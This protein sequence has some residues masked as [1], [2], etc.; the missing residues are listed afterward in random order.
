MRLIF[1]C[2]GALLVSTGFSQHPLTTSWNMNTTGDLGTYEYYPGPPPTTSTVNMTDSTDILELCESTDYVFIRT[3]GLPSYLMGPWQMNPN[4]P[5]AI[6]SVYR[7]PKNPQEE[8]G[9]KTAQPTVGAFGVAV[10][11]AKLYGTGD[12]RS[13]NSSNG[14]NDGM[15]DGLWNADAWLSEGTTMDATGGGHPDQN[16]NYHYH[17]TPVALYTDPSTQHSPIIGWAFDGHPIYGPFG[18]TDSLSAGPVT[19]MVSSWELRNITDRTLLPD[20]TTSTPAGPAINGTFPLGTYWEDYEYV[21][22]AG[23]LDEYNGRWC[24][25]P[26]Y[27]TGTYAYFVTVDNSGE[28]QFPYLMGLE[29]YG[30]ILHTNEIG[31]PAG[32]VIDMSDCTPLSID[33]EAFD[34]TIYP[35]PANSILNISGIDGATYTIIDQL[36]RILER[37]QVIQQIDISSFEN[38]TYTILFDKND[39]TAIKRFVKQ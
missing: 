35:N 14:T 33:E 9:A 25:T 31:G 20:G 19:R 21:A 32:T 7:F 15:G 6:E 1:T 30:E 34:F 12:A 11:G 8:T 13:Y 3:N 22:G 17:A 39:K 29:Y 10:N 26:E 28:P 18:F 36:G 23:T 16:G 37:G 38:G 24:V 4:V 27:P 2:I 5:S